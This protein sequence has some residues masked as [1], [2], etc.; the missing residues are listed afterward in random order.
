MLQFLQEL[1]EINICQ[2]L[3]ISVVDNFQGEENDIILLSLVRSNPSGSIGFLKVD[4]RVCV[5]LS[6]A[7]QG[8]FIVGNI[9]QMTAR[10][11]LWRTI[12]ETL[13]NSGSIGPHMR[14]TCH[15][16]PHWQRDVTCDTDFKRLN[17]ERGCNEICGMKLSNCNH[18]CPERC[19][20][21]EIDHKNRICYMPCERRCINDHQCLRKCGEECP[22]CTAL[23]DKLLTCGHH[24]KVQCSKLE[25]E[26]NRCHKLV[27]KEMPL[28]LHPARMKCYQN[29]LDLV[30]PGRCEGILP[31]SH[32]CN[33]NCHID[34]D[35]NHTLDEY[36]CRA[37]VN[38]VLPL[39][40]HMQSTRCYI[41]PSSII[42]TAQCQVTLECGHQRTE[43]CHMKRN[44]N[45]L[46]AVPCIEPCTKINKHCTKGHPCK[47]KCF[48]KCR[49]CTKDP[50][51]VKIISECGHPA[52]VRHIVKGGPSYVLI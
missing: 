29:P 8:L 21:Y 52:K 10:S 44:V 40:G 22:P 46:K 49:E 50:K 36:H 48:E 26:N 38:K 6:R 30:C 2:G 24:I 20:S 3:R 12:Q 39:C 5:A 18:G 9:Q 31:C 4:N 37:K 42:C 19:H 14:L 7:R 23:T 15:R 33:K 43:I 17:P 32:R 28:C 45:Q 25:I 51:V 13:E 41:D 35:D 34:D 16:H 47:L 1:R 27:E 11:P